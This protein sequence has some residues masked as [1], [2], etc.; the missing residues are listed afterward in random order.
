MPK[1]RANG[2]VGEPDASRPE[3]VARRAASFV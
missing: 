1:V 3:I 2:L